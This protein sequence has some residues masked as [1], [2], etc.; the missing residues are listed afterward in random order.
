[1]FVETIKTEGLSHLS[2]M[3]GDGERAAVIDPRR[4]FEVYEEMARARGVHIDF[5]FETHRNEDYVSGAEDL[6]R[7]TGA[8]VLRGPTDEFKV[9]YA[10]A[11]P[12]GE[13]V[14]VGEASLEVLHTPG[15]TMDSISL[16]L[17]H[18]E[19][20]DTP[21]G[22]F[23]GDALFV[24]DVGRTDF[25]PGRDEE[26][27]GMLYDSIFEK[28]LPLGDQAVIWPAHG[29]GS[30]CGS[31]MA[32]RDFSTIGYER[33]NNPRLKLGREDF[34][35]AKTAE[36]HEQ[37]PYFRMMETLNAGGAPALGPRPAPPRPIDADAFI[38]R[39]KEGMIAV[40][41]LMAESYAGGHPPGSVALPISL[42]S[43][44]AGW[45]L[46]Y[47]TPL[48]LIAASPDQADE[49]RLQLA[50][51]GYDRVEG[52]LKGGVSAWASAGYPVD[53]IPSIDGPGFKALIE[54]GDAPGVL[55]VRS[56]DEFDSGHLD[57]AVNIYA[58]ELPERLG[59]LDRD[60]DWIVLCGTG[61]RATI[62][63]SVLQNAGFGR[64]RIFWGS[65]KACQ[66]LGCQ[67]AA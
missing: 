34:I 27:S 26:V 19:T 31:G 24:G 62:A 51:M 57:G 9:H 55:D 11:A 36:R 50:R 28:I 65:M 15:H 40:D 60:R 17:R 20:G 41:V 42:L 29:S 8:T 13:R 6:S 7:R 61:Q 47:D 33:A 16:V 53:A 38:R 12:E 1:M 43:G 45:L 67:M 32:S 44:F 52:Y 10:E 49:A 59:E 22:V 46:P 23:T 54:G 48:G 66:A 39:M 58:G 18:H 2:Y 63:A 21:I 3:V 30:V 25:Y 5:I 35:D 64:V 56:P 4:D 14:H 37:P